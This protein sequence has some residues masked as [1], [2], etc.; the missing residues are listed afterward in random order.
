MDSKKILSADFLDILFE[1]RN[2]IYGAYD[3]RKT[4]GRRLHTALGMVLIICLLI[5]F[6]SMR[7]AGKK[8]GSIKINVD[9]VHISSIDEQPKPDIPP[10][11]KKPLQ[12]ETISYTIPVIVNTDVEPQDEIKPVDEL[13]TDVKIGTTDI[14]GAKS[15]IVTAPVEINA[16]TGIEVPKVKD[17]SEGIFTNV[18]IEAKFKGGVEAWKR[19]L[20]RNLNNSIAADNGA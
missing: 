5:S 7:P 14:E 12:V 16:G 13:N 17:L 20:E 9:D 3:L 18:S 1:G 19:F 10:P 2:K 6:F 11:L 4:Y 15:D 8:H